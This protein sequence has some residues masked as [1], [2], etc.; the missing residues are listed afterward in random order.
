MEMRS[1]EYELNSF[2]EKDSKKTITVFMENVE[3]MFSIMECYCIDII[4]DCMQM[5]SN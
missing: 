2:P 3:R 4:K 1:C 5:N